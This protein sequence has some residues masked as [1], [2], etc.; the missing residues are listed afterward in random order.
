MKFQFIYEHKQE[1]AV[2]LMCKVQVVSE[3]GY[4]AWRKRP[5][6]ARAKADRALEAE[7]EPIFE[8]SRQTYGSP[9]VKAAL[10]GKGI[11]CSR[12]RVARLMRLLGLVSCHRRKKRK[13]ITTDSQHSNPVAPNRLK[14]DFTATKP[15]EKW[16]GDI[17]GVWTNEGWL[18]LAK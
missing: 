15:D 3:S 4:Y 8:Q 2:R 6:S 10:R 17:T 9:R 1:F 13:V 12:K 14:R 5:E 11:N 16:V 18:Y 7:I